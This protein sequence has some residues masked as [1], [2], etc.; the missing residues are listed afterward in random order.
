MSSVSALALCVRSLLQAF[1]R[2]TENIK[3]TIQTGFN[4]CTKKNINYT[5]TTHLA[6]PGLIAMK[7]H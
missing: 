1:N 5:C 2:I 4:I 3:P 7:L 6:Q